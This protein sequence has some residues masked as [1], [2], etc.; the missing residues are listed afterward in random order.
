MIEVTKVK[1]KKDVKEFI[2]FPLKLYKDNAYFV[3]PLYADE[4]ALF[5]KK[6]VYSEQAESVFFIAKENGER[7]GAYKV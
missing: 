2:D 3:P 1:T 4:K 7:L 6:T 5:K